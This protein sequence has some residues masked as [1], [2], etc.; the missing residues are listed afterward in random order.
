MTTPVVRQGIKNSSPRSALRQ[1]GSG[2]QGVSGD[3]G[4]Y[5]SGSPPALVLEF[6]PEQ[7]WYPTV[8][9]KGFREVCPDPGSAQ[10]SDLMIP[11]CPLQL[12]YAMILGSYCF[13]ANSFQGGDWQHSSFRYF[14]IHA[15]LCPCLTLPLC[16]NTH[17][18]PF[19]KK[20]RE[21]QQNV[22]GSSIS[23]TFSALWPT[24]FED[25]SILLS[26]SKRKKT[27]VDL[28]QP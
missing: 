10:E 15:H 2:W 1:D 26:T 22:T 28:I 14:Q 9:L 25:Y 19:L 5:L 24:P 12:G 17:F 20:Q 27:P 7:M 21:Q 4:W 11:E 3:V 13:P 8:L 23:Y 6:S 16:Q 18:S